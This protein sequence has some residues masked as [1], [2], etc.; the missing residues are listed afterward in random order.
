[1]TTT[2][3]AP[4][5]FSKKTNNSGRPRRYADIDQVEIYRVF[6]RSAVSR[7]ED[8]SLV[9]GEGFFPSLPAPPWDQTSI[10]LRWDF[11]HETCTER[12]VT[13]ALTFDLS[14]RQRAE[15]FFTTGT[16]KRWVQKRL[17]DDTLSHIYRSHPAISFDWWFVIETDEDVGSAIYTKTPGRYE[18]FH[19][20]AVLNAPPAIFPRVAAQLCKRAEIVGAAPP[21]SLISLRAGYRAHLQPLTDSRGWYGYATTDVHSM[22]QHFA[23]VTGDR[24]YGV[25][26]TLRRA[27]KARYEDW[28]KRIPVRAPPSAS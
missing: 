9:V 4:S 22:L 11:I 14:G 6:E 20:H 17:F 3:S 24:P 1:M 7:G 28:C 8:P 16:I 18:R 27:A 10:K 15:A 2:S 26:W 25:S 13:H 19:I 23:A 12:G 5:S 21:G